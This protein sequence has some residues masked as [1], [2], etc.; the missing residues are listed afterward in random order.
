MINLAVEQP[1]SLRAATGLP[2]FKIDGRKPHRSTIIRYA[3]RGARSATGQRVKLETVKAPAGFM[4][5]AEAV[6][7]FLANLNSPAITSE[8]YASD[9]VEAAELELAAAGIR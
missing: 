2:Q 3:R 7:R 8:N 9:P 6:E 4:T 5:T 1:I